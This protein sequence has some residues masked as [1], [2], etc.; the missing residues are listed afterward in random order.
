MMMDADLDS[1]TIAVFSVGCVCYAG[2]YALAH[3]ATN[4]WS[5]DS[6]SW[7]ESGNRR[8]PNSSGECERCEGEDEGDRHSAW[9]MRI[10]IL[11]QTQGN[12]SCNLHDCA[13]GACFLL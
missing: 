4:E 12:L 2:T 3:G 8:R 6:S 10:K 1:R 7:N 9:K 5:G 13:H 11:I